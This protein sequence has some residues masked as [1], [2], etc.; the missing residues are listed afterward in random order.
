MYVTITKE[1]YT[2]NGI[3]YFRSPALKAVFLDDKTVL[4]ED[5]ILYYLT[6]KEICELRNYN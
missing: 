6:S 4:V 2:D 5:S 3:T 1:I